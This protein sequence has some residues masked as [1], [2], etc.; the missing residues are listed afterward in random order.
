[1]SWSLVCDG[2]PGQ[3]SVSLIGTREL[4]GSQTL[5]SGDQLSVLGPIGTKCLWE[6]KTWFLMTP[7]CLDLNQLIDVL[8][9]RN[10]NMLLTKER[11][12]SMRLVRLFVGVASHVMFDSEWRKAAI[13]PVS[14][15]FEA[16]MPQIWLL[17]GKFCL[18]MEEQSSRSSSFL[19]HNSVVV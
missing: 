6:L 17:A 5:D 13:W 11:K 12:Y 3:L 10:A 4:D 16:L 1:M 18:D 14:S 9:C 2:K 19:Y 15:S 8:A 7:L